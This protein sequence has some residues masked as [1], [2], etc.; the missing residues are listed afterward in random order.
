MN[1]NNIVADLD[2]W[3]CHEFV[4]TMLQFHLLSRS[5]NSGNIF[6]LTKDQYLNTNWDNFI[7]KFYICSGLKIS[8]RNF[9]FF[10]FFAQ[11]LVL[12]ILVPSFANILV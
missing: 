9:F 10:F 2:D 1:D 7:Y 4:S 5:T 12:V 11:N 6:Y 3:D 8:A